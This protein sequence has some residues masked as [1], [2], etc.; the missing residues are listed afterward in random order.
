MQEADEHFY[1][2]PEGTGILGSIVRTAIKTKHL[3]G[4]DSTFR[5]DTPDI[6]VDGFGLTDTDQIMADDGQTS[7]QNSDGGQ[8]NG[9]QG[10]NIGGYLPLGSGNHAKTY[11]FR[12]SFKN[13]IKTTDMNKVT[14]TFTRYKL[15]E[16]GLH[17]VGNFAWAEPE[18]EDYIVPYFLS[19]W[20]T[21][22][23]WEQ[24]IANSYRISKSGF[25]I[26]KIICMEWMTKNNEEVFVPN[27]NPYFDIYKDVGS[28]VGYGNLVGITKVPK[29]TD[30]GTRVTTGSFT[31]AN[32]TVI[33]NVLYT[34]EDA[35]KLVLIH[36]LPI[37]RPNGAIGTMYFNM[38]IT[39]MLELECYYDSI[40]HP[41]KVPLTSAKRV[42]AATHK[43]FNYNYYLMSNPNR[44]FQEHEPKGLLHGRGIHLYLDK[45][46]KTTRGIENG[47][48][49][50]K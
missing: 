17:N 7:G 46:K 18:S 4:L 8:G 9:W 3:L 37:I 43:D 2:D 21:L 36:V 15:G 47:H 23:K 6:G 49:V 34:N 41:Q 12:R 38:D 50:N 24:T 1:K 25:M 5:G 28:Y 44:H 39:Y 42:E 10:R 27:H 14:G 48:Y 16:A 33:N 35:P 20:V 22:P 32:R 31:V 11:I 19:T 45:D 29:T 40:S 13:I 30:D 26:D